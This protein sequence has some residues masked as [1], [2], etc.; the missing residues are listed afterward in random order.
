M[1]KHDLFLNCLRTTVDVYRHGTFDR[2]STVAFMATC[3]DVHMREN[4]ATETEYAGVRSLEVV[5]ALE[6][7][8][9]L[10]AD[11]RVLQELYAEAT[12]F[13]AAGY[14]RLKLIK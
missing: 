8:E 12:T 6:L 11:D 5:P 10:S 9:P 2:W 1:R 4:P 14:G 7:N 3:I 13:W